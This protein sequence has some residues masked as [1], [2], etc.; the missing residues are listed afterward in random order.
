MP[1]DQKTNADAASKVKMPINELKYIVMEGGGAR[2][3]TYLGAIEALENELFARV[4]QY[5]LDSTLELAIKPKEKPALTE[6]RLP[7]IMDYLKLDSTGENYIPI[8]E[9]VAGASA[10]AITTFALVLGLNSEEIKEVLD[11]KFE[12]FISEVDAGKYRMISEDSE[13]GIGEDAS[14]YAKN[15]IDVFEMSK[16]KSLGGKYKKFE[17]DLNKKKTEIQGNVS[18]FAKREFAVSLLFKVIIDGAVHNVGQV[19]KIISS[20]SKKNWYDKLLKNLFSS[21]LSAGGVVSNTTNT[22]VTKTLYSTILKKGLF[23]FFNIKSGEIK[24]TSNTV[25]AIFKDRGMFSGF[26]VREFFYDLMLF[27][28]TR[29]TYFQKR[30]IEF[31]NNPPL[32]LLATENT[33]GF[34][35]LIKKITSEDFKVIAKKGQLK[36]K[37]EIGKRDE[38]DYNKDVKK[39]FEHLQNITFREFW[40]LM[41]IE[42]AAAVSNFTT[43]S[44]LFFSDKYTPNFRILESV[45]ASMSIPPAIRPV[46]NASDAVFKVHNVKNN[47]E[48]KIYLLPNYK[49]SKKLIVTI[50]K[51]PYNFIEEDGKFTKS[52]YEIIEYATKKG[53][54][55]FLMT[56]KGIYI[57]LNNLIELNTFLDYLQELIIGKREIYTEK[58]LPSWEDQVVIVNDDNYII[59]LDLL[60]FFYNSQFKGLLLDG[61]YF[62]N[63]PF[64]YFREKGIG[65]ELDGVLPIKLDGSFP[66]DFLFEVNKKME[67]LKNIE[68]KIIDRVNN[69][70]SRSTVD[71]IDFTE[72]DEEFE[73]IVT[74]IQAMFNAEISKINQKETRRAMK[75]AD[76]KGKEIRTATK[77]IK[78]NREAVLKIIK[79]WHK[80]YG[81]QNNIKPW[82]I[83]RSIIEIAFTGYSYGSKRGQIRDMSDHNN[84][85]PLYDY[86]VGTYDFDLNKV[87]TLAEFAQYQAKI[88]VLE[89]FD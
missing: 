36:P 32:E 81:M 27:A 84:I 66:P 59:T 80:E 31:Y 28:A 75:A 45:A 79:A 60:L 70:L 26:Q 68:Q 13:L 86:G 35:N 40:H 30:L 78:G 82:E 62:N 22:M 38:V 2:G 6:N 5:T 64:N 54:Q 50:N 14:V 77:N 76:K 4:D 37:F 34:P 52:D 61:G 44:P 67:R 87:S 18:K 88:A 63:I 7:G 16:A 24:V 1:D 42:Y 39:I 58:D 69:E 53:I 51:N 23:A 20:N 57:D 72:R 19:L 56:K 47:P 10:G 83:P 48:D 15:E 3:N 41:K 85:I 33:T 73:R 17:Y 71:S 89:Y 21:N 74:Q 49:K 12:N 25:A 55:Q 43:N 65:K 8:I 46:Y 29:D 9:G 11:F